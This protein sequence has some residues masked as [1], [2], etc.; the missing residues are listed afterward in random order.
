MRSRL[1]A[2]SE[3]NA[4]RRR[5]HSFLSWITASI[6]GGCRSSNA[7]GTSAGNVR[8]SL[9]ASQRPSITSGHRRRAETRARKTSSPP[10]LSA[11]PA[12]RERRR[13][14]SAKPRSSVRVP[15]G[16]Q[17]AYCLSIVLRQ[18]LALQLLVADYVHRFALGQQRGFSPV[19]AF[20]QDS[21]S[22]LQ[23][24][25]AQ[26]RGARLDQD[27]VVIPCGRAIPAGRLN[28]RQNAFMLFFKLAVGKP[29]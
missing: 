24:R 23:H 15:L 18:R 14:S 25:S 2:N 8:S 6:D 7:M 17:L 1:A 29:Q 9:P 12:P 19:S 13:S 26:H 11:I 22:E 3:P 10:A 27:L 21:I 20:A 16:H 5:R 28:D 4:S